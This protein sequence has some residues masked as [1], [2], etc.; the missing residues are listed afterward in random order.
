LP[1]NFVSIIGKAKAIIVFS[2]YPNQVCVPT[3]LQ[4]NGYS[5]HLTTGK[6]AGGETDN[7]PSYTTEEKTGAI[8]APSHTLSILVHNQYF[9][10]REL[11]YIAGL[12]VPGPKGDEVAGGEACSLLHEARDKK[13]LHYIGC[14]T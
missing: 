8:P 5:G 12:D 9:C 14:K 6:E 2:T 1:R 7:S 4:L 13:W 3:T 11:A 10:M